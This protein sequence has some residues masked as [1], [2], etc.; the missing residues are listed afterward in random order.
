[1]IPGKT[2]QFE[3]ISDRTFRRLTIPGD[4]SLSQ[5]ERIRLQR[6]VEVDERENGLFV[7]QRARLVVG[8]I[9]LRGLTLIVPPPMP[10]DIFLQM[11]VVGYT[12]HYLQSKRYV[13]ELETASNLVRGPWGLYFQTMLATLYVRWVERLL[14]THVA[15]TY[16]R[17]M[18]RLRTLRGRVVWSK[19]FGHHPVEGL[20]CS[21]FELSTDNE[22]NRAILLGLVVASEFLRGTPWEVAANQQLFMWRELA[23]VMAPS[24]NVFERARE[25]ITGLTSHYA[26]A[27]DLAEALVLRRHPAGLPV[28]GST[29]LQ[30]MHLFVDRVLALS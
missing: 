27:I 15:Q 14:A 2:A 9:A 21:Y 12:P 17:R 26:P 24:Q 16:E 10:P 6:I 19:T 28:A 11:F 8:Q 30:G 7:R 1:V 5:E 20:P 22:L 29:Y 18:K 13:E 25:R 23:L 4:Q 3:V